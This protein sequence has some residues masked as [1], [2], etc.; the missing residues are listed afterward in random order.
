MAFAQKHLNLADSDDISALINDCMLL[1][2]TTDKPGMEPGDFELRID[3]RDSTVPL[4]SRG[5]SIEIL[6]GYAAAVLSRDDRG[7]IALQAGL[8]YVMQVSNGL[9][10][11]VAGED[12]R[13]L[14][15]FF[16]RVEN[17]FSTHLKLPEDTAR[18]LMTINT[19]VLVWLRSNSC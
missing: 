6:I 5:A 15:F 19:N 1:L 18:I 16:A 2:R 3:D 14:K 8:A 17:G 13:F 12:G 10:Q 9:G 11:A 7:L 4:P